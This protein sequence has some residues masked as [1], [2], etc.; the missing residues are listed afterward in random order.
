[1]WFKNLVA[2]RL[3]A[4]WKLSAAEL[5][6]HLARHT[7]QP[8]SALAML[9]RGWVAPASTGRLLHTVNQQHLIALGVDQKLLPAS[10][11][12]QVTKERADAQ[13]IELHVRG[14]AGSGNNGR[15]ITQFQTEG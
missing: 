2:Y 4:D 14:I 6:E 1:M 13:A 11:I 12:R 9:S 10:I 7:L 15:E 5:E 8:C 3:P